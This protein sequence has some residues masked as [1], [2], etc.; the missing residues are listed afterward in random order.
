MPSYTLQVQAFNGTMKTGNH[1]IHYPETCKEQPTDQTDFNRLM[2]EMDSAFR[3]FLTQA[4]VRHSHDDV[5]EVFRLH[6]E[7]IA[8]SKKVPQWQMWSFGQGKFDY[9]KWMLHWQ[10]RPFVSEDRKLLSALADLEN[11]KELKRLES[12]PVQEIVIIGDDSSSKPTKVPSEPVPVIP[13][14]PP[15]DQSKL[16]G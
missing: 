3:D 13:T 16:L 14:E 15:R 5:L 6:L 10:F 9:G 11:A 1:L 8:P 12:Q 4:H 2:V 7:S